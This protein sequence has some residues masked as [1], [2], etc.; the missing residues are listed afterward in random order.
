V[1]TWKIQTEQAAPIQAITSI[2]VKPNPAIAAGLA[3][4]SGVG[5]APKKPVASAEPFPRAYPKSLHRPEEK[6]QNERKIHLIPTLEVEPGKGG[7][8]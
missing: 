5:A 8:R 3:K 1:N 4:S 7:A 6:M 2:R